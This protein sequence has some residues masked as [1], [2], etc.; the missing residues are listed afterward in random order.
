MFRSLM[1]VFSNNDVLSKRSHNHLD[2]KWVY[3]IFIFGLKWGTYVRYGK[4]RITPKRT[5]RQ[6]IKT[7]IINISLAVL[8]KYDFNVINTLPAINSYYLR[9]WVNVSGNFWS[10]PPP[11]PRFSLTRPIFGPRII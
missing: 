9:R 1:I 11:C 7:N 5:E 10:P 2:K 6:S 3:S 4:I 8:F